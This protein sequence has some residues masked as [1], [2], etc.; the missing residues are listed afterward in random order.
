MGM[1]HLAA[2]AC[3]RS[4]KVQVEM[5]APCSVLVEQCYYQMSGLYWLREW[6]GY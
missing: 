6:I 2:V 4:W 1:C 5:V 3:S